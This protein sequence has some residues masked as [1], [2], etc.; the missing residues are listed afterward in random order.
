MENVNKV[1]DIRRRQ[2]MKDV[3]YNPEAS[4]EDELCHVPRGL[5]C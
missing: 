1:P 3:L 4:G 5:V 2:D